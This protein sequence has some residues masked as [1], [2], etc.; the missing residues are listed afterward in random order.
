MVISFTIDENMRNTIETHMDQTRIKLR[1]RRLSFDKR[2]MYQHLLSMGLKHF[3]I[4]NFED[5]IKMTKEEPTK[6]R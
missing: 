4:D 3:D 5:V 2:V 6:I 1:K